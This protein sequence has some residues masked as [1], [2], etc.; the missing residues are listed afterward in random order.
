MEMDQNESNWKQNFLANNTGD[1]SVLWD[2]VKAK[3]HQLRDKYVS[4]SLP[5]EPF[6]KR[7][8]SVPLSLE[9][10]NKIRKKVKG[11]RRNP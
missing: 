6:W 5:E 8:A 11:K 4:I 7:K 2:I 1:V 10:R 9:V 3:F